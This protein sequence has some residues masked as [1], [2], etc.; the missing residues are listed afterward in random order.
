MRTVQARSAPALFKSWRQLTE[1]PWRFHKSAK[2]AIPAYSPWGDCDDRPNVLDARYTETQN[3]APV[4]I[5]L[6][7]SRTPYLVV[8]AIVV[9][10]IATVVGV[11]VT[12]SGSAVSAP[13]PST[14][15]GAN[16]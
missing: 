10:F 14:D 5:P 7:S 11:L 8:A 13:P 12:S 3:D 15:L 2:P 1:I 6:T 9:A 16:R 4:Q